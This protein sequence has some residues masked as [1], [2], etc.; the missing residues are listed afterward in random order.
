MVAKKQIPTKISKPTKP[1]RPTTRPTKTSSLL[2]TALLGSAAGLGVGTLGLLEGTGSIYAPSQLIR[3]LQ[4]ADPQL[5]NQAI[6]AATGTI[7]NWLTGGNVKIVNNILEQLGIYNYIEQLVGSVVPTDQR[8]T[9][10]T[11]FTKT[12]GASTRPLLKLEQEN[13]GGETRPNVTF[14]RPLNLHG[15]EMIPG[16]PVSPMQIE[17]PTPFIP[18]RKASTELENVRKGFP[19]IFSPNIL[20][21]PGSITKVSQL[22][23]PKK[24]FGEIRKSR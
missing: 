5:Y 24:G 17:M 7:K 9:I 23:P 15:M 10:A 18:R 4:L 2:K 14:D 12:I 3:S 19:L 6:A 21:T 1:T 8:E 11:W 13:V 16:A 20:S 22:Y